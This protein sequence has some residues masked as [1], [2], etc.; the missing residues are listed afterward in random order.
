MF[1]QNNVILFLGKYQCEHL[2]LITIS[3][4]A[5]DISMN[6][7]FL[8]KNLSIMQLFLFAI[9]LSNRNLFLDL[10]YHH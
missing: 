1:M 10:K 5:F 3:V 4:E 8:I 6:G 9:F 2:I 7:D